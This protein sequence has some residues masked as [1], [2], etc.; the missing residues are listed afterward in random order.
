[1]AYAISGKSG[2]KQ[3]KGAIWLGLMKC[4]ILNCAIYKLGL[5]YFKKGCIV[6][7]IIYFS[8]LLCVNLKNSVYIQLG[9]FSSIKLVTVTMH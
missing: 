1:M 6:S 4:C 9:K 7:D 2:V 5:L 8:G 3:E